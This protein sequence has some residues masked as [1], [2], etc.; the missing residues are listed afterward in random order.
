MSSVQLHQTNVGERRNDLSR[1]SYTRLSYVSL[2]GLNNSNQHLSFDINHSRSGLF[3]KKHSFLS[4][5]H[6]KLSNLAGQK[7]WGELDDFSLEELRD[8]F[9]DAMYSK[10]E[11]ITSELPKT[12]TATSKKE[13][14]RRDII[15]IEFQTQI[16]KLLNS[17]RTAWQDIFKFVLAILTSFI[18]CV[19]H[20]SGKWIGGLYRC[21]LPISVILHHPA[22]TVGEQLE[23]SLMSLLGMAFALGWSSLAWYISTAT[24]PTASHQGG[25]L[26]QS[27]VMALVFATW[28]KAYYRRFLYFSMTFQITILFFHTVDLVFSKA[29]LQWSL[30]RDF[31]LSYGFGI[32]LSLLINF[33]VFPHSGNRLLLQHFTNTVASIKDLLIFM[34]DKDCL[35]DDDK[36]RKVQNK[37]IRTLNIDLSEGYRDFQNQITISRF[38]RTSLRDL[39]N[40]LT[41]MTSPLR[42][43]Q[44]SHKLFD[45]SIIDKLY[46]AA[47]VGN[48]NQVNTE[49][50]LPSTVPT[51]GAQ[52]PGIFVSNLAT[53]SPLPGVNSGTPFLSSSS[54]FYIRVLRKVFSKEVFALILEMIVLLEKIREILE[55]CRATGLKTIDLDTK[56]KSLKESSRK[57]KKKIYNLDVAYKKFTRTNVFSTDLLMD[58]E[59]I[60]VLLFIRS[61]RNAA[62]QLVSVVRA[63]YI[64]GDN[65]KWHVL[66]P[67]IEFYRALH[68][69]P[70]QSSIDDGMGN[71][72]H[73]YETKRDVDEILQR[74]YNSYT[75]RHSY[76]RNGKMSV[77]TRAIDHTDFNFHTTENPLRFK[78]WKLTTILKGREMKWTMKVLFV[79]I[80]YS[81]PTWLPESYR[82]YQHYQC[83]WGP[84]IFLMLAHNLVTGNFLSLFV[85]VIIGVLAIFWG[86][87]ANQAHHFGSPYVICVFAGIIAVP[88]AINLIVYKFSK[89]SF[90]ALIC[91]TVISLEPF[92]KGS[93]ALNTGE[94][95]KNTWITGLSLLIGMFT[96]ITINWI[97]WTRKAKTELRLAVSSLLA[98]LS[99]SYQSVTERYLYRDSDDDPTKLTLVFAHIREVRL[100]QSLEAIRGL[101][102]WSA[103][104]PVYI[105]NFDPKLYAKLIDTCQ[106]LLEKMIEARI[107]SSNFD[108]WLQDS[109]RDVTRA[110]LSV[111]RDSVASVI[112]VFY[113]LSNCFRSRNKIPR[114]LPNTILSRKKLYDLLSEF[115]NF[116]KAK[117]SSQLSLP[118]KKEIPLSQQLF[119]KFNFG[120]KNLNAGSQPTIDEN[121]YLQSGDDISNLP[122]DSEENEK[123]QWT[124]IYGAAFSRAFTDVA[125]VVQDLVQCC[126]EILGEE[127]Y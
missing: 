123:L 41:T 100:T 99:Q 67:N 12:D 24:R 10:P 27:M 45:R 4:F 96:S 62:K 120:G 72:L 124:E 57:L 59:A 9:F 115:Y 23:I 84:M 19:I 5:S 122:I 26:F 86:W 32:P 63:T 33:L 25:I 36:F 66:L 43:I 6:V 54:E 95:W 20:P 73:Y 13:P 44:H 31:S 117:S 8:G 81:L 69:L 113:I 64:V 104:E 17:F 39:R 83:W 42:S 50:E 110:L 106:F 82:W 76:K 22:R 68:R 108:V 91:F 88:S 61:I 30:Y 94:I 37:M 51:S 114:Y 80:F 35:E 102:I 18:I 89:A 21:F 119:K 29:E 111:R 47:N 87:A 101:L 118:H 79:V 15:S 58:T 112:F 92:A 55:L 1:G 2:H 90:S 127:M 49:F 40:K 14:S 75:S 3:P 78:L 71:Y 38:D 97:F 103:K 74:T 77:S 52:T 105:S 107:A 28:V 109:N 7:N 93:G 16:G 126:K 60:D 98:H 56:R 53:P 125:E 34:V 116:E 65:V 70:Y 121:S 11:N 46:A 48:I 85:R